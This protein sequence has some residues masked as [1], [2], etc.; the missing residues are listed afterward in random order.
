MTKK[1]IELT[2]EVTEPIT[3]DLATSENDLRAKLKEIGGHEGVI[4]YILRNSHTATIDLRDPARII[5]YAILS[6][7]A[8]DT[9]KELSDL[10]NIGNIKS[11]IVEGK[12]TKILTMIINENRISIFMEKNADSEILRKILCEKESDP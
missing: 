2:N 5:D 10:F 11:I 1:K 4:G 9:G 12:K 8:I 6:S 7:S 3:L